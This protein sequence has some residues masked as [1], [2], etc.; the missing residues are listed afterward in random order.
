LDTILS[1]VQRFDFKKITP[2][3]IISKL[4]KVA[5]AEGL[6]VEDEA[7][8]AVA[9]IAGGS[10]RDAESALSKI[11]AYAGGKVTAR[12]VAEILGIVPLQ[13]HEVLIGLMAHKKV[14]EAMAKVS[15]LYE[16]GID[17]DHFNKQF[18]KYL[19][20]LL[21]QKINNPA[22]AGPVTPEYLVRAINAFVK[23]GAEMKSSPVPQL[24]LELAI[25]ELT[26]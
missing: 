12:D 14:Q 4:R 21:I 13:E 17:L 9:S 8:V 23:A 1:R 10:L 20:T 11:I 5:E 22:D 2:E 18:I 16:G 6:K 7:L 19:R 26:K 24:P 25:L 15:G 3:K